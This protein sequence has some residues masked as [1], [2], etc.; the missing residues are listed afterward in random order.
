MDS[1]ALSVI[2]S[3]GRRGDD[4]KLLDRLLV[5]A[6]QSAMDSG[7]LRGV[8]VV[9]G[10][11]HL[12]V[13]CLRTLSDHARQT[14]VRL[15]LMIDQPAGDLEKTVGTG[16][17]VCVLKMYNH[18][19]ANMAAEFIGKG[20]KF[21]L[22]Q[23]TRLVGKSFGEGGNDSFNATTNQGTNAKQNRFGARGK[24]QGLSDSRGHTWTGTR[25]WQG[26]DNISTSNTS[27]RVYEFVVEPQEIL[28]M[29]ET[30]FILVDNTGQGRRV[31]MVDGNPGI[32]LLDRVSPA[33]TQ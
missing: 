16:G 14:G 12:G 9:A 21:V 22:S 30:S 8:L 25:T 18:R 23:V 31:I 6:A 5:Q 2:A 4:D 24:G 27:G 7:S 19:D 32:C 33:L 11:D 13:E 3:S 29:P 20:H 17:A 15:V 28:G 10:G 1:D 26:S